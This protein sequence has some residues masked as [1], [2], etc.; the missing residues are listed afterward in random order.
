[1]TEFGNFS[2]FMGVMKSPGKMHICYSTL[3]NCPCT[4]SFCF[5]QGLAS[6]KAARVD[7]QEI[8]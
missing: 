4:I 6:K 1:M 2:L 8:L 7:V 3:H 5:V